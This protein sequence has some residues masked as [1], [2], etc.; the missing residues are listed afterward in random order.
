MRNNRTRRV[1]MTE[2][3][4]RRLVRR[5]IKETN[6]SKM[7]KMEMA[8]MD[9][10]EM[11]VYGFKHHKGHSDQGYLDREGDML[12]GRHGHED[13]EMSMKTRE[14]MSRGTRKFDMGETVSMDDMDEMY[15]KKEGMKRDMEEQFLPKDRDMMIPWAL[16]PQ[17][18][19]DTLGEYGITEDIYNQIDPEYVMSLIRELGLLDK[20]GLN[21]SEDNDMMEGMSD[22]DMVEMMKRSE[23]KEKYHKRK[24]MKERM[25]KEKMEEAFRRSLRRSKRRR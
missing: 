22:E 9:M 5:V 12:G 23:M 15:M 4:L 18:V 21:E 3:D 19:K 24:A 13:D 8:D 7:D 25:K 11:G 16:L 10:K 14:R 1:R 20:L 6:H 2:S 17:V